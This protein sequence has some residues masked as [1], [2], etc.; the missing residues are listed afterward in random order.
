VPRHPR[1]VAMKSAGS[2]LLTVVVL[3]GVPLGV[4]VVAR[5]TAHHRHVLPETMLARQLTAELE[6]EATDKQ[7]NAPS[8]RPAITPSNRRSLRRSPNPAKEV[9][10]MAAPGVF[11]AGRHLYYPDWR[12]LVL[13]GSIANSARP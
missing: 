3:V 7:S 5:H 4:L 2:V 8:P 1:R 12:R 9:T 13:A 6:R 11:L 10:P